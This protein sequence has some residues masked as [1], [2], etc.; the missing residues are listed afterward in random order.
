MA[1]EIKRAPRDVIDRETG[2]ITTELVPEG[3]DRGW[4][5]NVGRSWLGA[6][7]ALGRQLAALPKDLRAA[8]LAATTTAYAEAQIKSWRWWLKTVTADGKPRGHQHAVGLLPEHL[9][10]AAADRGATT[11]AA[12]ITVEDRHLD[13][14]RGAHKPP[15]AG[16]LARAIPA[17]ILQDLPAYLADHQV[18]LWDAKRNR[19]VIV[20]R[21]KGEGGKR[22]R[23]VIALDR[24]GAT[25]RSL[26]QVH[27]ADLQGASQ[28]ELIDG[29]W[30]R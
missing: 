23:A 14:L 1:P 25:V 28:Y 5:H 2:E 22:Y 26:G 15:D 21:E 12:L 4:D 29:D 30:E 27:Q 24:R 19:L 9:I 11:H 18:A 20:L 13:H 17:E 8:V 16:G 3:I 10:Q 7:R 6:D